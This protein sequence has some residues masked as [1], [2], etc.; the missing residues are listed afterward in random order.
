MPGLPKLKD[1]LQ[2]MKDDPKSTI[3][4]IA[5]AAVVA[6]FSILQISTKK[7][8]AKQEQE[9]AN[10][11]ADAKANA[12]T[13]KIENDQMRDKMVEV[14]SALKEVQGEMNTLRKLGIIK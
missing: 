1:F 4:Y 12:Y 10:C 9:I 13:C 7:T 3:M 11:R 14:L 2:G 8:N 6:L 5:F